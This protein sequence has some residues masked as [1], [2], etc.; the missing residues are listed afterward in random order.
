MQT[1]MPLLTALTDCPDCTKELTHDNCTSWSRD[2]GFDP[3]PC[4][5]CK[6]RACDD[7]SDRWALCSCCGGAICDTCEPSTRSRSV[8]DA[9]AY[10]APCRTR[11][12]L[13]CTKCAEAQDKAKRDFAESIGDLTTDAKYDALSFG[14]AWLSDIVADLESALRTAKNAL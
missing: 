3:R 12:E 1:P 6:R 9:P 11:T 8:T 13:L 2:T 4:S 7:C 5:N 14:D 10:G